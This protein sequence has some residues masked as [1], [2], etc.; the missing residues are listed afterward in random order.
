MKNDS[1]IMKFHY[2]D[3][4]K[5]YQI[6]YSNSLLEINIEKAKMN[7]VFFIYIYIYKS[8]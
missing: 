1:L 2:E 6:D 3:L 4:E 7:Q 8:F 5:K